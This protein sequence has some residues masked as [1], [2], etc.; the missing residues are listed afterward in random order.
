MGMGAKGWTIGQK[1]TH[2]HH[3]HSTDLEGACGGNVD[4]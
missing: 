4:F 1:H 2:I 3:A